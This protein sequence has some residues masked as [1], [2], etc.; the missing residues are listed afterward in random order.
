MSPFP[1]NLT[2]SSDYV[3]MF[4]SSNELK[5]AAKDYRLQNPA[6]PSKR[7]S[8]QEVLDAYRRS[9][10]MDKIALDE[11]IKVKLDDLMKPLFVH[12]HAGAR[13]MKAKFVTLTVPDQEMAEALITAG[14]A[15]PL[16]MN[17]KSP[18]KAPTGDAKARITEAKN[19]TDLLKNHINPLNFAVGTEPTTV[20][21]YEKLKSF[22]S[23][24]YSGK[25]PSLKFHSNFF[26][27]FLSRGGDLPTFLQMSAEIL[28]E[29]KTTLSS[30]TP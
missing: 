27:D 20:N 10:Y 6:F 23:G 24:H 22:V 2:V 29:A 26:R 9:E 12:L 30:T 18:K 17:E 19:I 16:L 13:Y 5:K 15:F 25:L 28:R 11:A 21:S 4:A 3:R 14:E 1:L 7:F 8:I